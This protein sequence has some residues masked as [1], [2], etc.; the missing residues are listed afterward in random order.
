MQRIVFYSWQSDS[1]SA[2]NRNL[3]EDALSRAVRAIRR[4]DAATVEPVVDRDTAGIPGA[5]AIA[6]SIYAKIAEAD[7]FVADVTIVNPTAPE[8]WTLRLEPLLR[9]WNGGVWPS[10]LITVLP[11][12]PVSDLICFHKQD[13]SDRVSRHDP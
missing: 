13:L 5:P 8:R 10:R 1:P 11:G 4:D 9:F 3:I 7:V 6:D 2:T 12:I